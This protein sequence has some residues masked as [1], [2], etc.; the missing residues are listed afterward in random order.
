MH[1]QDAVKKE[2]ARVAIATGIGTA[3]MLLVFF[4]LHAAQ[5]FVGH[6][7]F[8]ISEIV[9]GAIGWFVASLNFFLMAVTVQ[10][11]AGMDDQDKAKKRMTA[12]YRYRMIL[13]LV[14]ALLSFVVPFFNPAA[15]I[16]PLFIPSIAI[17]LSG[18]FAKRKSAKTSSSDSA[19]AGSN[20][21]AGKR[22]DADGE[23]SA[24]R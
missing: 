10:K 17:K 14:W 22:S 15:G 6:V 20:A 18:I 23:V 13:Q 7:P 2:A 24:S 21:A 8:G 19:V 3:I 1:L 9:S 16:I 11:I 12:S 5:A 4:I